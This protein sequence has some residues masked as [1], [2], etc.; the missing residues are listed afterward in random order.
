MKKIF[1]TTFCMFLFHPTLANTLT[2]VAYDPT[3]YAII[4]DL[5][6]TVGRAWILTGVSDTYYY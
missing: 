1:F 2:L 5:N 6:T 4:E 3:Y